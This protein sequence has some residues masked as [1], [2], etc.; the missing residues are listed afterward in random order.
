MWPF[1]RIVR[2]AHIPLTE[3]DRWSL[4]DIRQFNAV[5]DMGAS[6]DAAIHGMEM[7][8]RDDDRKRRESRS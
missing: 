5:L 3:L 8:Q 1:W 4:D 7:K 2:D 6:H